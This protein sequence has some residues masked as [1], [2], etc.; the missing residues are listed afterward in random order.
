M[1]Q[2]V[3]ENDSDQIHLQLAVN[4]ANDLIQLVGHT[5]HETL[6]V[7]LDK[8][9]K[10]QPHSLNHDIVPKQLHENSHQLIPI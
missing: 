2:L 10:I 8:P 3:R 4:H 7:L 5:I 9:F 6:I 1:W